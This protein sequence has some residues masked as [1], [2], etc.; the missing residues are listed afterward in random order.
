MQKRDGEGA[1]IQAG[2]VVFADPG[3]EHWHGGT[4]HSYVVHTAIS[5]GVAEW[6]GPVTDAEYESAQK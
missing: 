2:D 6:G 4:S 1:Y 5:M 3:E